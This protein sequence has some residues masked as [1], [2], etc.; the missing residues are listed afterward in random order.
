[1]KYELK[2]VSLPLSKSVALRVMTL[3]AVA[4][5]QGATPAR[6]AVLPDAEDVEGMLRAVG[7]LKMALTEGQRQS[8]NIG[9]GGAPIRFFTALAA[10]AAGAEILLECSPRL[11]QRPIA[12]LLKALAD[13]GASVDP[14]GEGGRPPLMIHG[15][16]ID[17]PSLTIDAGVSSQYISALLMAAPLWESGIS[18]LLEG[19]LVSAPYLEMTLNLMRQFGLNPTFEN[20]TLSLPASLITPPAEIAIEQDW[21]AASYFY[22]LALIFGG[23]KVGIASLVPPSQSIQGDAMCAA[24]FERLGVASTFYEDGSVILQASNPAPEYFEGDMTDTPDLVPALAVAMCLADVKFSLSGVHHLRVKESDRLEALR[25]E[26]AKLG[27]LLNVE[28]DRLSWGGSRCE[29]SEYP[30][31]ATYS[32]HRMA[33]AFAPAVV[34][35]PNIRIENPEVVGKSFPKFWKAI[36]TALNKYNK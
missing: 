30:V 29:S 25:C 18:L 13:A 26:L 23:K 32:D 27:Y 5:L 9:E 11:A 24:I 3:N 20:N 6:I 7:A 17:A 35:Y 4:E 19:E 12:P 14:Q 8:V 28:A 1:M 31:I 2:F 34:K 16:H 21:S 36:D 15:R 22:E 33:M 10:S